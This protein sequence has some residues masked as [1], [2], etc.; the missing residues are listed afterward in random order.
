[1][2]DKSDQAMNLDSVTAEELQRLFSTQD[3]LSL[4]DSTVIPSLSAKSRR[5]SD[6]KHREILQNRFDDTVFRT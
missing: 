5:R 1:M 2:E 6:T 4:Q 3:G